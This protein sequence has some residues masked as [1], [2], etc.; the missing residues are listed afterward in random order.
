[1]TD[2]TDFRKPMTEFA[3]PNGDHYADVFLKIQKAQL[4]RD[5]KRVV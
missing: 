4:P 5:R 2:E 1:M 3:G